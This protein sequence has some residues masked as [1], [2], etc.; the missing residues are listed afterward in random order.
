MKYKRGDNVQ[1]I[2]TKPY[3]PFNLYDTAVV[4]RCYDAPNI[5]YRIENYKLISGIVFEEDIKP[6]EEL[7]DT[8]IKKI[9]D[10]QNTIQ[11]IEKW[12]DHWK[13]DGLNT[14]FVNEATERIED[15]KELL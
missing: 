12:R 5:H 8:G 10:L 14:V 6:Y 13:S 4:T 3:H 7:D 15:L 1:V 2:A 11:W 9:D